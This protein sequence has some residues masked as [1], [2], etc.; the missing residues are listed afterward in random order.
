MSGSSAKRRHAIRDR[1]AETGEP[2]TVAARRH[3]EER[4][5]HAAPSEDFDAQPGTEPP[6]PIKPASALDLPFVAPPDA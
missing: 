5:R 3:D 6:A 4:A 2:W 1:M